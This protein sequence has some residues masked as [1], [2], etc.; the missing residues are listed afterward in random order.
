[1]LFDSTIQRLNE[2]RREGQAFDGMKVS[3]LIHPS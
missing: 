1:M 3:F 2:S